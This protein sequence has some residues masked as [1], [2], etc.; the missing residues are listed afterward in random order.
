MVYIPNITDRIEHKLAALRAGTIDE[1]AGRVMALVTLKLQGGQASIDMIL[2][3]LHL[4]LRTTDVFQS[5]DNK[6]ALV[7]LDDIK[8]EDIAGVI[9]R[10]A[11]LLSKAQPCPL[12]FSETI[13]MPEDTSADQVIDR[14]LANPQ[15]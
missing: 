10:L 1:D 13:V 4:H 7:I 2:R 9:A 14:A 8:V 15:S 12:R 11:K 5:I 6:T 3:E